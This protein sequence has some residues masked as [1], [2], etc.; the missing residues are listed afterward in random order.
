[1]ASAITA[2]EV[3][4]KRSQPSEGWQEKRGE[5]AEVRGEKRKT[6]Y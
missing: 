3:I 5:G 4:K 2:K 1:V 6:L